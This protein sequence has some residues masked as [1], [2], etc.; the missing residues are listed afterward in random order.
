M[1]GDNSAISATITVSVPLRLRLQVGQVGAQ[2]HAGFQ[3]SRSSLRGE[4]GS[5]L[6]HERDVDFSVFNLG[7]HG[8]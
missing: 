8:R 2:G 5:E 3:G 7:Q 4:D 6:V 1:T